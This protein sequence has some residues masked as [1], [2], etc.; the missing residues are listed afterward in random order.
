VSVP[1]GITAMERAVAHSTVPVTRV[2]TKP[3]PE[4]APPMLL[5]KIVRLEP[6]RQVVATPVVTVPVSLVR[7]VMIRPSVQLPVLILTNVLL[8]PITAM[9]MLPVQT[10]LVVFLVNVTPVILVSA[11]AVLLTA[12]V[13]AV[14]MSWPWATPRT[15]RPVA[16]VRPIPIKHPLPIRGALRHVFHAR[17]GPMR[18]LALRV[19]QMSTS[20]QRERT[21]VRPTQPV[22]IAPVV[23]IVRV[24][25]VILE[26]G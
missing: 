15:I 2:N 12:L 23:L 8:T 25:R 17:V 7:A 11:Q 19:V 14:N 4:P 18:L 21:I 5:V 9:P 10:V 22:V 24:T 1:Q 6:V 3:P 26:M 16:F 20:V 13:V